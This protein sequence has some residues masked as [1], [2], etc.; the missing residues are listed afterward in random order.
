MVAKMSIF[1]YIRGAGFEC[2]LSYKQYKQ[3]V[4]GAC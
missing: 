2:H 3:L 1:A 4:L